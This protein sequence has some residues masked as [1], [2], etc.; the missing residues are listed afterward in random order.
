[1]KGLSIFLIKKLYNE[2]LHHSQKLKIIFSKLDILEGMLIREK[3]YLSNY[4]SYRN[5]LFS[6]LME[7][8]KNYFILF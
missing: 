6:L 7:L 4:Q 5:R 3:D 1:M 8:L 2:S